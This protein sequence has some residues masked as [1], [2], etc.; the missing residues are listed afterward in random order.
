MLDKINEKDN[1]MTNNQRVAV[2]LSSLHHILYMPKLIYG[3]KNYKSTMNDTIDCMLLLVVNESTKDIEVQKFESRLK[4]KKITPQPFIIAFGNSFDKVS[5]KFC[6]K[7]ENI[8]YALES[9]SALLDCLDLILKIYHVVN[10]EYPVLDKNV[11]LFL[12]TH[13]L[14][15][16]SN[17][18]CAKVTNLI[19]ALKQ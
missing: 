14:N 18:K 15:V 12:S 2:I 9:D 5:N 17:E 4:E 13:F 10:L 1:P 8:Q 11:Y 16:P 3:S 7:V 19:K 6:V